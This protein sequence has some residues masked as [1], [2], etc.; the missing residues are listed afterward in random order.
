MHFCVYGWLLSQTQVQPILLVPLIIYICTDRCTGCGKISC[1]NFARGQ[2]GA[3]Q[4]FIIKQLYVGCASLQCHKSPKWVWLRLEIKQNYWGI[5]HIFNKIKKKIIKKKEFFLI[6]IETR[7]SNVQRPT[8]IHSW[9]WHSLEWQQ[10][11]QPVCMSIV[12]HTS[13]DM[14]G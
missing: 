1:P 14:L 13:Y 5:S 2:K 9:Q 12:S 3:Q 11:A 6:P 8:S 10:L 4:R 7:C